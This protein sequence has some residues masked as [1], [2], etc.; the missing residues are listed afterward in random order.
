MVY[1]GDIDGLRAIAVLSVIVFHIDAALLPGGFVGVDVFFVISG[2]LITGNIVQELNS[3]R[4]SLLEFYRRRVKRIA[5]AMLV[6]TAVVMLAAYLLMLPEQLRDTGK[7][8]VF[9]LA[10]LANVYFWL[11]QDTGYFAQSS[12]ELPLLHLWSLGVEEQFYL[13]W[14]LLLVAVYRRA[15]KLTLVLAMAACAVASFWMGSALFEQAPSFVYYMLPSRAGELLLGALVAVLVN[16][17][18][19][20]GL[21]TRLMPAVALGGL[22]LLVASL[23]FLNENRPFPGWFAL[24]PTLGTALLLWAGQH[25]PNPV[26]RLLA[27]RPLVW[28][29]LVSYSAY[30]WH[31]PLLAFYRYGYGE[32][33]AL[34]GLLLFIATGALAWLSYRFVEQPARRAGGSAQRVFA[35]QFFLPASALLVIALVLVYPQRFGVELESPHYTAQLA[36]LRAA[37]QPAFLAAPVCQFQAI[38]PAQMT[39]DRC[40][41]GAASNPRVEALLWGDSNAAHYQGM[42][43]VIAQHAGFRLRNIEIGSCPPL[44]GNVSAF[45]APRRARDCEHASAVVRDAINDYPVVILAGLWTAYQQRSAE[46]LPSLFASIDALARSHRLVVVLGKAPTLTGYDRKC[47]EKALKVPLLNCPTR[48]AVDMTEVSALNRQ[49]RDF[50]ATRS[51]VRYFDANERLCP[52]GV[53]ALDDA[54]S[55]VRYVDALHLSLQGARHLGAEIVRETGIPSAFADI[56]AAQST[57]ARPALDEAAR[58]QSR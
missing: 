48:I 27:L 46:F 2:Y 38:T 39:L 6:V 1:R 32:V 31:W 42:L 51:N 4:F 25:G 34:A 24:P 15:D 23:V 13:L 11:Y 49:L 3:G 44:P 33:S 8:A 9:S 47:R 26:T 58:Q 20:A 36:A 7:S 12:L 40:V 28:V 56:V 53:C 55:Q 17:R 41:S 45:V 29:G 22:L 52:A 57:D 10:S 30:L 16:E 50:A 21:S 5:P 43:D 37:T 54:D 18:L 19:L 35:L 14:P